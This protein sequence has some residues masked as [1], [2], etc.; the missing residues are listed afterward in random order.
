MKQLTAPHF[1]RLMPTVKATNAP[2]GKKNDIEDR[3]ADSIHNVEQKF[4]DRS[5][6]DVS[7]GEDSHRSML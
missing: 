4:E 5:E 3:H 1:S 2:N 7:K 6:N